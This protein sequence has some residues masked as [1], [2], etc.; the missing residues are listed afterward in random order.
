MV[1]DIAAPA[2]RVPVSPPRDWAA[3]L[4][5]VRDSIAAIMRAPAIR[6]DAEATAILLRLDETQDPEAMDRALDD[7]R[8]RMDALAE[9][10]A[11]RFRPPPSRA[12]PESLAARSTS[13]ASGRRIFRL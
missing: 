3:L 10:R 9:E 11:A 8:A 2:L 12:S 1:G 7:L 5:E 6:A 13:A 4:G